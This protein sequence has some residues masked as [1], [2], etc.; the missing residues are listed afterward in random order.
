MGRLSGRPVLVFSEFPGCPFCI[1]MEATSFRNAEVLELVADVVPIK[2]DLSK[3]PESEWRWYWERYPYFGVQDVEGNE[4]YTFPGMHHEDSL[5]RHLA[6]GV[7]KAAEI[8]PRL[9]WERVRTL[10]ATLGGALAAETDGRLGDA[11]KAYEVLTKADV[12]SPFFDEGKAGQARIGHGAA[13]SLVEARE[14][15]ATDVAAAMLVLDDA[16]T[17]FDGTPYADDLSAALDALRERSL[18]PVLVGP[19]GAEELR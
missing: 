10:S 12:S 18:F 6:L 13:A 17:R 16:V 15:A 1:E 19:T 8:G 14:L 9:S 2:L 7:E 4:L 3:M 11:C 5:R